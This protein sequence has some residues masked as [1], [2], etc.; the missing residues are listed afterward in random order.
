MNGCENDMNRLS[1]WIQDRCHFENNDIKKLTST[2][3]T[4]MN[5]MNELKDMV[6]F[7]KNNNDSELWLSYSGHG[8]Y[9]SSF[10]ESDYQ[11]EIICPCDYQTN[12]F[13]SDD[14]LRKEFVDKLPSDCKVFVIMDC[15]HSGSNMDLPY[16][17]KD[18]E[19]TRREDMSAPDSIAKIIKLSGCLDNQVSMDYYNRE[20]REFQ[21]AFT[22]SFV[23][24]HKE[25]SMIDTVND[26]NEYLRNNRFKQ[27]SELA[28]SKSELCE[29]K[30]Y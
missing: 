9:Y 6:D 2:S 25:L 29:W 28:L 3:A 22:N 10:K 26:L 14:W 20:M 19:I 30:I 15:C 1:E 12:G 24:S 13:I 18:N 23:M 4:K 8:S 27:I 7:A 21:G 11:N 17:M 16:C 5:I